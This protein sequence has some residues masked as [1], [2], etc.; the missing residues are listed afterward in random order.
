MLHD[1]ITGYDATPLVMIPPEQLGKILQGVSPGRTSFLDP[2]NVGFG[3]LDPLGSLGKGLFL[4][5]N[6]TSVDVVGHHHNALGKQGGDEEN[7][8]KVI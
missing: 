8:S 4:V 7:Q 3:Q 5:D 2:D 6:A 1:F